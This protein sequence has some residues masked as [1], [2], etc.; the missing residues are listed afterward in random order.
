MS[1]KLDE[2]LFDEIV[3]QIKT[4]DDLADLSRQL[5]K[6]AVERVMALN[7]KPIWVTRNM[8]LMG[9]IPATAAMATARKPS[10]VILVR[11]KSK[12]RETAM[13]NSHYSLSPKAKRVSTSWI[14]RFWHFTPVE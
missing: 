5:L 9:R 3:E 11:S 13:V 8:I 1:V 4:Q 12:L 10:R 7:S 6:V 2:N 14:S